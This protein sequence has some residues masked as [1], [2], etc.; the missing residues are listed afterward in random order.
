[1]PNITPF[2]VDK[3]HIHIPAYITLSSDHRIKLRAILDT[4]APFTE[5]SDEFLL[6]VGLLNTEKNVSLKKGQESQK[7]GKIIFPLIE[8]CS[9]KIYDMKVF[10]SR[11]EKS[12][13][14]DAL[15]GLDFFRRFKM[16]IDYQKGYLIT[17]PLT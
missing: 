13:G 8:I 2:N 5:I 12:W 10:I 11:F 17:E 3:H 7:Y 4:G 15:I 14:I 16:T 9:H 1:M 6:Y